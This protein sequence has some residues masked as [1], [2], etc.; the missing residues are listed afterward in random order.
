MSAFVSRSSPIARGRKIGILEAISRM[1]TIALPHRQDGLC[2][3]LVVYIASNKLWLDQ[4]FLHILG[5]WISFAWR[6]FELSPSALGSMVKPMWHSA[7][8]ISAA[9]TLLGKQL[10]ALAE[11]RRLATD[12]H[13]QAR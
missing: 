3:R 8:S 4:L 10:Q 7:S 11:V 9:S 12:L 2:P 13:R 6:F 5:A 1:A